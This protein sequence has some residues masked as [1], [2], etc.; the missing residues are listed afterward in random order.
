[1][2]SIYFSS[3]ESIMADSCEFLKIN[4]CYN[5]AYN[6]E[7]LEKFQLYR[8]EKHGRSSAI[9]EQESK[10]HSQLQTSNSKLSWAILEQID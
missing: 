9:F 4:K 3:R 6:Q 5:T 7:M 8:L 2:I 10:L 1:M